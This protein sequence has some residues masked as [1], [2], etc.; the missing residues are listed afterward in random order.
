[1]TVEAEERSVENQRDLFLVG[2]AYFLA[3][4]VCAAAAAIVLS[5]YSLHVQY[6]PMQHKMN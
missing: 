1:M 3:I 2:L 5:V 6:S 4:D